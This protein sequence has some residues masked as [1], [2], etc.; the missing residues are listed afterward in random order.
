[1]ATKEVVKKE[2]VKKETAISPFVIFNTEIAAIRE[3]MVT[4]VGDAGLTA[5]DFERIKVPA[6]GGTAW[7]IQ[8]LDPFCPVLSRR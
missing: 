4:N 6:G 2:V 1:M 8:G 3:A 5:G 7:T